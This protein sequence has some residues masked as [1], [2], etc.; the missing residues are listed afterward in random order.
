MSFDLHY[1]QDKAALFQAAKSGDVAT[2]RRLLDAHVDV[3]STDEVC[4]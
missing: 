3:N 1:V 4:S 2:I